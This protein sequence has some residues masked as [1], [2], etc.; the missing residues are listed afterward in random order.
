MAGELQVLVGVMPLLST[1]NSSVSLGV[2]AVAAG[3]SAGPCAL[4]LSLSEGDGG[5]CALS[6]E[7]QV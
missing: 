1:I 4:C 2:Q 3:E 5:G 7:H 6:N